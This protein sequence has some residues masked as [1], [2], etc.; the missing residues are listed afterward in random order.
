MEERNSA[1]K[2]ISIFSILTFAFALQGFAKETKPVTLK[3]KVKASSAKNSLLEGVDLSEGIGK[4]K[5]RNKKE[6]EAAY[7]AHEKLFAENKYPSAATC[8]T[9]HPKHYKEWSV[10]QHAYS[11]LSPVYLSLSNKINILSNGSNGDFCFRCHSQVGANLGESP[12]ISNLKRHPTSREGITC[13]VCHRIGTAYNKVSG[14]L[15]LEEGGLHENIYGPEGDAELKRVLANTDKYRVVTDPNE[16]G[17]VIHAEVSQFKQISNP[18]FCGTCHDVTLF[19]GFRLEEAYSEYKMSP[20]ARNGVTCQD[21]HMGKK[22]GVVSGYEHGPAAIVGGVPTKKRKITNHFFAGPDYSVVHPGI[23]PHNVKAQQLATMEQWLQFDHKAGWGTRKF[24]RNKPK[25]YKFPAAWDSID[26]RYEAREI[27]NQQFKQLAWAKQK[28]IEVLKAG[29]L[30]KDIKVKQADRK[31]I[32]FKVKF[33]NGTDGHNVPTGFTGERLVWLEVNV[34]DP[35]GKKIHWS[36]DRDPNGDVRDLHSSY[37]HN[38]EIDVDHELCSIQSRFVVQNGRGGELEQVI[39]IPYPSIALPR[40]LPTPLSLIFT[41]EPTTE[42][43]H[44]QGIE[45]L[46][47]RWCRYKVPKEKMTRPGKYKIEVKLH[48]QMAPANLIAAIQDVGFD[49]GLSP[50]EVTKR[51]A[52]G[53]VTL[54][55]KTH[56]VNIE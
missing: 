56:F 31:G 28:R 19:N 27:L 21:C 47:H 33:A 20:A 39:P 50:R 45:P 23:F 9:C 53:T 40:V 42:R 5:D 55:E 12:M 36:G 29:F 26:D 24:E 49:Y 38:G 48:N 3:D 2:A 15:A 14:R 44:H 16:P 43:S 51:V 11:Q 17:R 32:K 6:K 1:L 30:L 35:D 8:A 34:Y 18:V 54:W 37:I 13:T 25:N 4:K 52:D 7:E 22:Q 41:G 46:G 10:S